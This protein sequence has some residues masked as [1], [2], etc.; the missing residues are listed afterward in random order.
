MSGEKLGNSDL[1]AWAPRGWQ[2][3]LATLSSPYHPRR[4][5]DC[6]GD[7]PTTR[8]GLR[9]HVDVAR[10]RRLLMVL[11]GR[12][13]DPWEATA[14]RER[15]GSGMTA[16]TTQ[17]DAPAF[18]ASTGMDE[19]VEALPSLAKPD[20]P[21]GLKLLPRHFE[22]QDR[23]HEEFVRY[24]ARMAF[25]QPWGISELV[26]DEEALASGQFRVTRVRVIFPDTTPVLAGM[27]AASAVPRA[28]LLHH[29]EVPS[30]S[31]PWNG[32]FW[33]GQFTGPVTRL[34][35]ENERPMG[36]TTTRIP[37]PGN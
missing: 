26:I 23:Y 37:A 7:P 2:L 22:A 3:R 28:V 25:E 36:S 8:K 4:T 30:S 21:L 18:D 13:T 19:E 34:M 27:A 17:V 20:W 11:P 14:G 16:T 24:V 1:P 31:L 5:A 12:T 29:Y 6:G 10:A 33:Y 15:Q 35:R 9:I 32:G